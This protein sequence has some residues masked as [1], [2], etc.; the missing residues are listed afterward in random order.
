MLEKG[1]SPHLQASKQRISQ[2]LVT[3]SLGGPTRKHYYMVWTKRFW[4]QSWA[5]KSQQS[6]ILNLRKNWK[7]R[8]T[9]WKQCYSFSINIWIISK[10]KHQVQKCRWPTFIK[11]SIKWWYKHAKKIIKWEHSKYIFR[12]LNKIFL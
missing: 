6:Q 1:I 3:Q 11:K 9:W 4:K 2:I 8:N 7:W 12:S 5:G 10:G